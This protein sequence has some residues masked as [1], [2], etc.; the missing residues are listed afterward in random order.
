MADQSQVLPNT[1]RE[2]RAALE[3]NYWGLTGLYNWAMG[4]GVLF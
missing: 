4:T 3:L 1:L 2:R